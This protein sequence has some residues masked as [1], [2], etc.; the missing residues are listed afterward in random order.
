MNGHTPSNLP[1]QIEQILASHVQ[2]GNRSINLYRC[3]QQTDFYWSSMLNQAMII[4]DHYHKYLHYFKQQSANFIAKFVKLLPTCK[5]MFIQCLSTLQGLV[6]LIQRFHLQGLQLNIY[7]NKASTIWIETFPLYKSIDLAM[8]NFFQEHITYQFNTHLKIAS[9]K[10]SS[11]HWSTIIS[12]CSNPMHHQAMAIPRAL[13]KVMLVPCTTLLKSWPSYASQRWNL[14]NII[15]KVTVIL[16]L[17]AWSL[18]II[19]IYLR[20]LHTDLHEDQSLPQLNQGYCSC[21]GTFYYIE[22]LHV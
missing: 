20:G 12:S 14:C 1:G 4:Q 3:L 21:Y 9:N 22:S 2:N 11:I 5:Y 17:G 7:Q 6:L 10:W 19:I 18:T 15:I 13:F 8:A 16:H